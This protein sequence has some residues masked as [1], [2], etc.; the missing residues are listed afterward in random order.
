MRIRA[1]SLT[2]RNAATAVSAF[3]RELTDVPRCG[4][5]VGW[6]G[7][8]FPPA[9]RLRCLRPLCGRRIVVISNGRYRKLGPRPT[10]RRK[11]TTMKANLYVGTALTAVAM[12]AAYAF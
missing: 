6:M 2:V 3:P 1:Q 12:A 7:A 8:A 4:A 11:V 9:Q 10:H 5:P